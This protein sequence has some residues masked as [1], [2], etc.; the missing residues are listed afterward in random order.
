MDG[1]ELPQSLFESIMGTQKSTNP[2]NIIKFS[3]NS[4]WGPWVP[5]GIKA[6][7]PRGGWYPGVT[8]EW[9]L[10]VPSPTGDQKV[11]VQQFHHPWVKR[12]WR[13]GSPITHG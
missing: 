4:R 2:N 3:D 1:Q 8:V 13:L 12:T 9:S 11:M 7:G 6:G 10:G 5:H